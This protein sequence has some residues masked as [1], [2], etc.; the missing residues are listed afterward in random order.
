MK[1]YKNSMKFYKKKKSKLFRTAMY[2]KV[3]ERCRTFIEI[4]QLVWTNMHYKKII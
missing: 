1:F 2:D 4:I 3:I